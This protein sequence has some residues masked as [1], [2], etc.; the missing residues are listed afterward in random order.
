MK[1]A[2]KI[3]GIVLAS[4]AGLIIIA[5]VIVVNTVASSERLTKII[6]QYVPQYVNCQM[7]LGRASVT[8]F[9]TFPNLGVSVE[10]VALVNPM[11]G[12]PSDTLASV[13][14]LNV[15]LD[16]Q[17]LLNEKKI[18]L[19]H[20][21]LE[22]AFL[23]IFIDKDGNNNLDVFQPNENTDTTVFSFDYLVDVQEI[24]LIN[25]TVLLTSEADVLT[26]RLKGIDMDLDGEYLDGDI[27]A[28][29]EMKVDDFYI[30][31]YA[32]PF[33]ITN[34]NIGF[35]GVLQQFETIKGVLTANKPDLKLFPSHT[36][37]VN[38]TAPVE[39]SLKDMAGRFKK[40][41]ASLSDYR[42]NFYGGVKIADNGKILIDF[43]AAS[44]D[45]SLEE[46]L[47]Y[48]PE[49]VQ[50]MLGIGNAK[51]K[52][53]LKL[54]DARVAIN[55]SKI[56]HIQIGIQADDVAAKVVSQPDTLLNLGFGIVLYDDLTT[57]T[58]NS[59]DVNALKVRI[60]NS[61]L[62]AKGTV[63]DLT[64]DVLLKLNVNGDVFLSD[65]KSL[66]PKTIKLDGRTLVGLTT[67][68]TVADL[69]KTIKDNNL[70]R[71][72]A[73]ADLGIRDFSFEMDSIHAKV[74][75]MNASLVL[76]DQLEVKNSTFR[77]GRSDLSMKGSIVGLINNIA[78]HTGTVK[79]D[80]HLDSKLLDVKEIVDLIKGLN[81]PANPQP[82]DSVK[83]EITPFLVPTGI[84]F[85]VD[86]NTKKTVYEDIDF[87]DLTG[88]VAMKD[89]TLLLHDISC[90][91]KAARME[92]SALYKSAQADNL[93]LAMDFRLADVLVHDFLHMIPYFDTLVPMLKTFDGQCDFGI[94][95]STS[96]GADYL[97]KLSTLRGEALIKGKNL[98][99][100]DHSTYSKITDL[101][102]VSTGGE[103]CVDNLDV[104]LSALDSKIDLWPSQ[105]AIGRYGAVAE[106]FMTPDK[107]MEYHISLT[108]SPFRMRHALKV[109]GP[110]DK[111]KFELEP[112]KYPN[113][114]TPL[115][116][117]ERKQFH[118]DLRK[119]LV[120]RLKNRLQKAKE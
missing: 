24:R 49:N 67:N 89:S 38:V 55:T 110:L 17:K 12:S 40:A 3:T 113:H 66:L 68:F 64:G 117:E 28:D 20:C 118:K 81:A 102:G 62:E 61:A 111:L 6:N 13:D 63:D 100:S 48:L 78:S 41:K 72:W 2:L 58:I 30:L 105:L 97:P 114:Y 7:E 39:F 83:K 76:P 5:A 94:D 115:Q 92:L 103:F 95:V 85:T 108:E 34:V 44:N 104:Q 107:N 4:L 109:W 73:K 88:T 120:E 1:K 116:R 53:K 22:N 71:L 87:N 96:L 60:K 79:G 18:V 86:V 14:E 31:N 93:F 91:N 19:R 106:G 46:L 50:E 35:T 8:F 27:N 112:S 59:I 23:N 52:L 90:S 69:N 84:D 10:Q 29:M 9:K 21:F 47:P 43:D 74:P 45:M 82:K 26:M 54:S 11:E 37:A 57:N 119:M 42:L 15:V 33:A 75:V 32:A 36:D 101:L 51:D 77:L 56:P 80:L 98:T 70:G 99:V 65:V 16:I 25:S